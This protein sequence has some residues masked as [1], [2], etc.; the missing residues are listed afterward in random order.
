MV[1]SF[2]WTIWGIGVAFTFLS[3]ILTVRTW[4]GKLSQ[5][6]D[7]LDLSG[8]S[9]NVL[10]FRIRVGSVP[11]FFGLLSIIVG[12]VARWGAQT[13]ASKAVSEALYGIADASY[14]LLGLSFVASVSLLI[15]GR[16]MFLI[17]PPLRSQV[18][19]DGRQRT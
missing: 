10:L 16:P 4:R 3:A 17:P 9:P 8:L 19:P 18:G 5:S 14:L 7:M 1:H 6:D 2:N 13:S 12:S 11:T 15:S